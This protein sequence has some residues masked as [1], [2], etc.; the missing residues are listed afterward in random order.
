[1]KIVNIVKDLLIHVAEHSLASTSRL[2]N[3]QE[4][5]RELKKNIEK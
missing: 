1:M 4:D 5:V 2:G 3:Y